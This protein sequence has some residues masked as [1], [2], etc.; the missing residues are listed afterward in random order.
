MTRTRMLSIAAA[1]GL[2]L[3]G[4]SEGSDLDVAANTDTST[5]TTDTTDVEATDGVDPT[6]AS[7]GTTGDPRETT[8]DEQ[9]GGEESGG[10]T[11]E[12]AERP[13]AEVAVDGI[14]PLAGGFHFELWGIIDEAPVTVGKFNIDASG[15]VVDLEGIAIPDAQFDAGRDL[16]AATD[17]VIT[18]ETQGDVDITPGV[19]KY[20]GGPRDGVDSMLVVGDATALGDDFSSA[21]GRFIL[22]TPTDGPDSDEYAGVWFLDLGTSPPT[23]GLDLPDLPPGWQYEGWAVVDGMPISTGRFVDL[24]QPDFAAPHSGELPGPTVPGEDLLLNA[25]DGFTFPADLRGQ[26]I[27]VSV[28]P[29]P[30]DSER[31]F[32]LKPLAVDVAENAAAAQSMQI[33]NAID[34]LP[35][36]TVRLV[37]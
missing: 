34:R 9:P 3:T 5:G 8:G 10:S 14:E 26:R 4:C 21:E 13:I 11:G 18:I 28:E 12:L 30:D 35:T 15:A 25:P 29:E 22:A 36:A 20:L 33:G 16:M 31:P 7:T 2:A 32:T 23:P 19:S 37:E 17:F 27:V 1:C 6:A 24:S